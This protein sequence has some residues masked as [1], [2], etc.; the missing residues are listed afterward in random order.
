MRLSLTEDQALFAKTATAF[1][2]ERS[3]LTR[4]RK[5]RDASDPLGY[6]KELWREMAR[7]GWTAIP[8]AEAHGGAGLGLAEMVLVTEGLG[9]CLAPEPLLSCVMLAGQALELGASERQRSE[10]LLPLIEGEKVLALA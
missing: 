5:L 1:A 9:R 7:L 2:A 10:S 4:V 6:S 8:F 3:P